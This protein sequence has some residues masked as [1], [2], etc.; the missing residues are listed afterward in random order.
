MNYAWLVIN[1]TIIDIA[2]FGNINYISYSLWS[3]KAKTP[4]IG[5]YSDSTIH[6]GKF[7]FYEDYVDSSLS[8]V[9][10]WTLEEYMNGMPMDTM[11]RLT[12]LFLNQTPS[13]SYIEHL[14]SYAKEIKFEKK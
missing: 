12:C 3:F 1:D 6:Y 7:E 13:H 4:Y 9:E 14:K 8:Q 2:F 11:W 10:G 5:S